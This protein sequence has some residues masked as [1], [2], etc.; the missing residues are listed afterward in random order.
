LNFHSFLLPLSCRLVFVARAGA[1]SPATHH[2]W[3]GAFKATARTL[4]LTATREGRAAPARSGAPS[5][6]SLPAD[7]LP[8]I[9]QP[10]AGPMSAWL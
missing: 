6:A 2:H 5:L 8:R 4:L 1:W 9:V 7:V 10:A 3:P